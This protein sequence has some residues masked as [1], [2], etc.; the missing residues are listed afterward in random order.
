M[1]DAT[2]FTRRTS[3]G[4]TSP[5]I[6]SRGARTRALILEAGLSSFSENGYHVT[7]VEDIVG[8]ASVSRA[9]LYQYFRNKEEVFFE[10]MRESAGQLQQHVRGLGRLGPD[11]EGF[12][13]LRNWLGEWMSVFERYAPM[14]IEWTNVNAPLGPIRE[15]VNGFVEFHTRVFAKII[16]SGG[17]SGTDPQAAAVLCLSLNNRFN[18]IRHIYQPALPIGDLLNNLAIAMQLFLFPETEHEVLTRNSSVTPVASRHR[19]G[20][21]LN[22]G[23]SS[24]P[25]RSTIGTPPRPSTPV[26]SRGAAE[27]TDRLLDAAASVFASSGYEASNIDRIVEHAGVARSTFYR[28][29]DDKLGVMKSLSKEVA[30]TLVPMFDD[31]GRLASDRD[32][33]ALRNWFR[34]SAELQRRYSGVIRAWT[35]RVP[36]D[37]EISSHSLDAVEAMNQSVV[38]AFGPK[39]SYPLSRGV[40]SM[41][42]ASIIEAFP[43]EGIGS[44]VEPTLDQ[45]ADCQLRFIRNVLLP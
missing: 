21:S 27:T 42:F 43:N 35:E 12:E 17:F 16:T 11:P 9:T 45:I 40:T 4:P 37:D 3:Y 25:S 26:T 36:H 38:S 1:T 33:P 14:F 6:G 7:S 39:R 20:R 18:Y 29:F 10:L 24:T 28:Y 2:T 15:G 22:A 32:F 13:N 19:S 44:K 8:K 34:T 30:D 41:M 31:F 23:R 5:R